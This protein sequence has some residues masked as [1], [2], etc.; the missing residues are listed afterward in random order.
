[1]TKSFPGLRPLNEN[2]SKGLG[3]GGQ[4]SQSISFK[5]ALLLPSTLFWP[6]K[7]TWLSSVLPGKEGK[8]GALLPCG[9]SESDWKPPYKLLHANQGTDISQGPQPG[10]AVSEGIKFPNSEYSVKGRPG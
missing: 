1:M 6:K 5:L 8:E 4:A 10:T 2:N 3:G 7:V 9:L